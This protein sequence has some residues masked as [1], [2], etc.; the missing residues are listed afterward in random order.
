MFFKYL[1]LVLFSTILLQASPKVFNSLGNDLEAFQEDCSIFQA[2][3][4]VPA[5]IKKQCETFNFKTTKAFKVGYYID[6]YIDSGK[7]SDK[8]LNN[9]LSLL[10]NLD[11][12]KENILKLMYSEVKKARKQNNIKDYSQL[13]VNNNIKLYSL[14][15]E[16]WTRIKTHL[17]KM[18]DILVI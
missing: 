16:L 10:R 13:I 15:Y 7:I 6:S 3:S 12:S 4:I 2:S 17:L 11:S 8:K 18:K 14:D 5:I 9:Y 1:K